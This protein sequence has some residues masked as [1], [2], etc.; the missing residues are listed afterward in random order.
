M[1]SKAHSF[2]KRR[3]KISYVVGDSVSVIL[4]KD[5][6]SRRESNDFSRTLTTLES[7]QIPTKIKQ[8][9][10]LQSTMLY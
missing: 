4:S 7:D 2:F 6:Q 5:G 10:A 3:P 9:M 8:H 1:L